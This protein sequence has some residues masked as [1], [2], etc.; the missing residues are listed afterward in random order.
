VAYRTQDL[1]HLLADFGECLTY[2]GQTTNVLVDFESAPVT[3]DGT[4]LQLAATET[5]VA[6]AT[7]ELTVG[8]LA[9]LAVDDE[10]D[11]DGI[12]Y[13]FRRRELLEDGALTAL[14][15]VKA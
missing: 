12:R 4:P 1:P 6:V 14:I 13:Q 10:F 9:A 7:A 5:M 3:M 2:E 11:V 8:I 15:V